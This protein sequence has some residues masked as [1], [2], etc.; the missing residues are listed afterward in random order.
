MLDFS[1]CRSKR[2]RNDFG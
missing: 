1:L 2:F